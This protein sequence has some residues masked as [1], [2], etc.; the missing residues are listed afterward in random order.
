MDSPTKRF[1]RS[2]AKFIRNELQATQNS[3]SF[4]KIA[5]QLAAAVLIGI[6]LSVLVVYR[7]G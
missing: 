4:Q 7:G 5:I 1:K 2:T 6:V 3:A